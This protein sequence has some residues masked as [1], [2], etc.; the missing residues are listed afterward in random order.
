MLSFLVKF[1]QMVGQTEGQMGDGKT[2]H[3]R[4]FNAGALRQIQLTL[5]SSKIL[6]WP[7]LKASADQKINEAQKLKYVYGG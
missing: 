4:S 2:I 7:K 3:P 5:P 1:V 6:D